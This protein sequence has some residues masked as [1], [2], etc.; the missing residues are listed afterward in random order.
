[1]QAYRT[2]AKVEEGQVIVQLPDVF[3]D[4]EVEVIILPSESAPAI[5]KAKKNMSKYRGVLKTGLSREAIDK[6]LQTLRDEWE[7]PI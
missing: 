1:M 7:R 3:S 2:R 6:Q 4:T 5:P